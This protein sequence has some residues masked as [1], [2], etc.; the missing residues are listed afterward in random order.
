MEQLL[1]TMEST[2]LFS[3]LV[4]RPNLATI[5]AESARTKVMY[6]IHLDKDNFGIYLH[7]EILEL[8][9]SQEKVIAFFN[10][11]NQ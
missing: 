7:G 11:L 1:K 8:C 6:E 9:E 5:F 3:R 4:F 2:G 10:N